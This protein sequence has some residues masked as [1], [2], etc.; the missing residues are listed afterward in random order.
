MDFFSVTRN[1]MLTRSLLQSDI[2][3]LRIRT[4]L[5]FKMRPL[6]LSKAIELSLV[7]LWR[8]RTCSIAIYLS[9]PSHSWFLGYRFLFVFV[10]CVCSPPHMWYE[11]FAWDLKHTSFMFK[12]ELVVNCRFII[13]YLELVIL[14]P[15]ILVT[16]LILRHC[17]SLYALFT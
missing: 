4:R 17:I 2:F 7:T 13:V 8:V 15:V 3:Q 9:L 16:Y 6:V 11:N 12:K 1:L 10:L 5:Y 14:T